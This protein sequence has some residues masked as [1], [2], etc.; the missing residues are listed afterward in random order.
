MY[1]FKVSDIIRMKSACGET[2]TDGYYELTLGNKKGNNTD[3]LWAWKG[4][5]GTP[6]TSG[7]WSGC[8]CQNK[9]KLIS[10]GSTIVLSIKKNWWKLPKKLLKK[11][12]RI[13]KGR[14]NK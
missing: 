1:N 5:N 11:K 6:N 3:T 2:I 12:K 14:S 7:G 8:F 4:A 9:W 13:N 10:R